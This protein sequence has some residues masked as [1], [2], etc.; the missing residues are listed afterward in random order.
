[1]KTFL[2]RAGL[3]GL[4]FLAATGSAV[5][6]QTPASP[7]PLR[8]PWTLEDVLAAALTQ[9]PVIEAARARVDAA[10]GSR[11][12]VG[13]LPN[14]IATYGVE[15]TSF[16]GQGLGTRLEPE[17]SAYVTFPL[18]AFFQRRPRIDR[19]DEGIRAAEAE[20]ATAER[21]TAR[22]V[23]RAFYRVA[24][25]QVAVVAAEE[26]RS[27]VER[28]VEYLRAR[29]AEGASPEADL[30]RAEVEREQTA[31]EVTLADVDL[32]RAR[33]DLQ[34]FLGSPSPPLDTL[35]VTVGEPSLAGAPLAPLAPIEQFTQH[36]SLRPELVSARAKVGAARAAAAYE[37]R[38]VIREAG[39]S[40][41]LKR[42]SGVNSMIAGLSVSLPIFDRNRGEIDRA[43]AERV[44]AERELAWI[45]RVVTAE[46]TGAYE[47]A[48][49]LSA[50]VAELQ[51]TFLSRA[52]ESS[53]ITLAAYQE[54]AATLLQALDAS[55]TLAAA[56]LS[57]SRAVFAQRESLFD[58]M[59]AAGYDSTTPIIGRLG[60]ETASPDG[61]P[62]NG[63]QR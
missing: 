15:D 31:T 34:P 10:R 56:R 37:R 47:V 50:R 8:T 49:R 27:A 12:T 36:G 5:V 39:A 32:V 42:T 11:R 45:E 41:G 28:L 46:V 33:S 1:M 9:H 43:T 24:L 52:E 54:G 3:P 2:F 44:A 22:E 48:R 21:H 6:A 51:R 16:P 30:I 53:R 57:Y 62:R 18:E 19:A 26:N 25:G 55:R 59:V 4:A 40:F 29:V 38:L 20:L 13:A 35:R 23:A 7:P 14:P 60:M 63:G 17:R 58:L 61:T